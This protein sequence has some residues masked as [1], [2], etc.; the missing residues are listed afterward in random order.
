MGTKRLV[1]R[2]SGHILKQRRKELI[3]QKYDIP[4]RSIETGE[5][6]KEWKRTNVIPTYKGGSEIEPLNYRSVSLTSTC[7]LFEVFTKDQ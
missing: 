4:K 6:T 3:D 1:N 7:K 2:V 5:V